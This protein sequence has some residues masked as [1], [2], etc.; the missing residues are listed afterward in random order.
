MSSRCDS[1]SHEPAAKPNL[2]TGSA[3]RYRAPLVLSFRALS[4]VVTEG[5][6]QQ[7]SH[8]ATAA[9][10]STRRVRSSIF[11]S[12]SRPSL[13]VATYS[14]SV[15]KRVCCSFFPYTRNPA[16]SQASYHHRVAAAK[17][18]DGSASR[19]R[20]QE[21]K[22]SPLLTFNTIFRTKRPFCRASRPCASPLLPPRV[23][24]RHP[25]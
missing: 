12:I 10:R 9:N 1:H 8:E 15:P 7:H 6:R 4:D 3:L 21:G 2:S 16:L 25:S 14:F 5:E 19:S 23:P 18:G 17:K 13:R 20:K 11:S 22:P 24:C